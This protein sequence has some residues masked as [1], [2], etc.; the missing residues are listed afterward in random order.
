[1]HW[2]RQDR[3]TL[4][5]FV[6]AVVMIG[7]NLVAIRYTNRELAPLWGSGSRFAIAAILFYALTAATRAP[8]PRGRGLIGA[9]LF[10]VIGVA[11]YFAF[12]YWG[13]V[14][15]KA[16]YGQVLL[17]LV[18]LMT[19][20]IAVAHRIERFSWRP[21]AGSLVATA[22][23]AIL[24]VDQI[25]V[26][27]PFLSLFVLILA[28]LCAAEG[29]IILKLLRPTHLIPINAVAMT[30]GAVLL[31]ALSFVLGESHRLPETTGV[32]IA[33][34]YLAT[35]GTLGTFLLYMYVLRHWTASAASYQYVLAPLAA[36]AL[37]AIFLGETVTPIFFAGLAL[38]LTGVYLGAILKPPLPP[39][40]ELT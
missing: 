18:P 10:G 40:E 14:E 23:V 12:V 32:W 24:F 33:Y 20:L 35:L 29:G 38:V 13:L 28:G 31:L 27:V 3:L 16:G 2:S 21:L 5:A 9:I 22:G 25:R 36:V 8:L 4:L 6:I 34:A 19:L 17:S 37:A 11:G 15:V 7:S 39:P 26:D 30:V 1:M